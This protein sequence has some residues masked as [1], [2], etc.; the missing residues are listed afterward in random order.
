MG[1]D[2]PSASAGTPST[3]FNPRARMGRD[4][5]TPH[6]AEVAAEV[7]IHAPIDSPH[8]DVPVRRLYSN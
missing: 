3:G 4:L 7:I 1:R 6:S 2:E 8:P 5:I